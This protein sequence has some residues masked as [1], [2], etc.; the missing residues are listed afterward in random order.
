MKITQIEVFHIHGVATEK[1][2][3][4]RPIIL[5]IDTDEGIYGLGEVGLAYGSASK[6]AVGIVQDLGKHVIGLDPFDTEAIW[7][8]LQKRTFWGQ[9]GGVVISAGISGIDIA[10]WD[11]KGKALGVPVYKL[12]GGKTRDKIRAYASQIHLDWASKRT[13][14]IKTEDYARN[15]LK[16]VKAGYDALKVDVFMFDKDGRHGARYDGP[17]PQQALRLGRDRIKAVREAV[18][19]D[20]DIIVENHAVTDVTSSIQFARA[21]EEFNI[22][23]YEEITTPLNPRLHRLAKDDI[24]IPIASGERIY[25]RWGFLPFI[26]ERSLDVV[27]PDLGNSGGLTETKKIADLA[28]LYEITVQ[29][30]VAGSGVISAAALHLE[31]VIP[32]FIIHEHHQKLLM[33]G[34]AELC[35]YDYQPVNGYLTVPEL[36]GIGQELTEIAYKKADRILIK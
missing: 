13:P 30:H 3:E 36:P 12:L 25:T 22:F 33:P 26:T 34:Y 4:Q 18:G 32:N 9:G 17:L 10:L 24:N 27:Q 5:R 2:S 19:P 14:A 6:A 15:A 1:A 20:V 31:T 29:V 7:D 35:L 28:A 11:I 16:A 8:R 23:Y 21:I